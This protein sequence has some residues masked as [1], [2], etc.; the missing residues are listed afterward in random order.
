M[1][2]Y[3]TCVT[4][5]KSFHWKNLQAGHFIDGRMNSV[6]FDERGVWPQCYACNVCKHGNKVEYYQ[7]M[8]RLHGQEVIDELR[9]LPKKTVVFTRQDY[10]DIYNKYRKING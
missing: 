7:H 4:C 5:C 8:M 6:L 1:D 3:N 10:D 2:G 9:L